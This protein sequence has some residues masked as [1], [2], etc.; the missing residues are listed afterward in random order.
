MDGVSRTTVGVASVRLLRCGFQGMRCSILILILVYSFW[1]GLSSVRRS[2]CHFD[3]CSRFL[4]SF[5]TKLSS[6]KYPEVGV[7]A[8]NFKIC[9]GSEGRS[10]TRLDAKAIHCYHIKGRGSAVFRKL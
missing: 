5:T 2:C 6:H 8:R 7:L 4:A 1:V 9:A 3:Y 10:N